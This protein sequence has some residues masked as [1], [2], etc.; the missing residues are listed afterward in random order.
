MLSP[1]ERLE[2]AGRFVDDDEDEKVNKPRKKKQQ[3]KTTK[4][5]AVD[6]IEVPVKEEKDPLLRTTRPGTPL[7]AD[8]DDDEDEPIGTSEEEPTG[9]HGTEPTGDER[10]YE[11]AHGAEP[12]DDIEVPVKEETRT[13][14]RS[15]APCGPGRCRSPTTCCERGRG[16]D[17]DEDE[18]AELRRRRRILRP[19]P[20]S[21]RREPQATAE[22][23]S[24]RAGADERAH[25]QPTFGRRASS[26]EPTS[27]PTFE[28]TSEPRASPRHPR[29]SFLSCAFLTFRKP[30]SRVGL[31]P[32]PTSR[33]LGRRRSRRPSRAAEPTSTASGRARR[34]PTAT[35][36]AEP[37]SG[38]GLAPFSRRTN[39][40]AP[41]AAVAPT[42]TRRFQ[43]HVATVSFPGAF[44]RPSPLPPEPPRL[45]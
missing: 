6:D 11:R 28:P 43:G 27:E 3:K 20:S 2:K 45:L 40:D 39:D 41:S 37:T 35:T 26:A 34:R 42:A 4:V 1:W 25:G 10:A 22:P 19:A 24:T 44:G 31:R 38:L 36:A 30:S 12:T 5:E 14:R 32:R 29:P 23:T 16:L 7:L 13:R 21:A 9:A 8:D 15:T 33:R 17:D 18:A